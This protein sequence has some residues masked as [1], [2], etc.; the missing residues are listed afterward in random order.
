MCPLFEDEKQGV[1]VI[2]LSSHPKGKREKSAEKVDRTPDL[3]IFSHTLS[4]L[5]YLGFCFHL[6]NYPLQRTTLSRNK[7]VIL[8]Y[9]QTEADSYNT[10]FLAE[11]H[12]PRRLRKGQKWA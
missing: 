3:M 7:Q 9:L 10:Y 11:P 1:S 4:Q 5:S 2:L 6:I 8:Q 12:T